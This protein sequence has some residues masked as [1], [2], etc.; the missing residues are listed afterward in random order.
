V[1]DKEI[2]VGK[3]DTGATFAQ[4][5]HWTFEHKRVTITIHFIQLVI[6]SAPQL[7]GIL[8]ALFIPLEISFFPHVT[9]TL[10]EA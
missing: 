7:F 3:N 6:V 1:T 10:E 2:L 9:Q 5:F 8:I 4:H